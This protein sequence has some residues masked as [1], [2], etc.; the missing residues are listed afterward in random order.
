M[1][2]FKTPFTRYR[3]R[4]VTTSS[5]VSLRSYLL[6]PLFLWL[7]VFKFC[8]V[9]IN[10]RLCSHDAGTKNCRLISCPFCIVYTIPRLIL[11]SAKIINQ[12]C[13]FNYWIWRLDLAP[14]C[15]QIE[16]FQSKKLGTKTVSKSAVFG[17]HMRYRKALRF[18][19]MPFIKRHCFVTV[20]VTVSYNF[21]PT[22][23][24]WTEREKVTF[25]CRFRPVPASCER[26][27]RAKLV[28]KIFNL[29]SWPCMRIR[30]TV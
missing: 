29:I 27:L 26:S 13:H 4:V 8:N 14:E 9:I 7:V 11:L 12:I 24:V 3:I 6:S 21:V 2:L 18:H 19:L 23:I 17:V 20:K 16:K 25:S 5:S 22:Y 30:G 15:S 1:T 10:V 28:L